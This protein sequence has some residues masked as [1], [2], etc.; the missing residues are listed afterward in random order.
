M[1]LGA[2]FYVFLS[3]SCT[4]NPNYLQNIHHSLLTDMPKVWCQLQNSNHISILNF[5]QF[6]QLKRICGRM[7][8]CECGRDSSQLARQFSFK[9]KKKP[10][11]AAWQQ[12]LL[13][14]I[15]YPV[16]NITKN[17]QLAFRMKEQTIVLPFFSQSSLSQLPW[18][19]V[20]PF[21]VNALTNCSP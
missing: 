15:H 7:S 14:T 20:L 5:T 10:S 12:E 8:Y 18:L 21:I 16:V 11:S 13:E 1:F 19:P 6:P 3:T 4:L 17:Y 2:Q 9:F